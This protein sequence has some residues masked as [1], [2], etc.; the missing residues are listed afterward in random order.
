[1]RT[2]NPLL[3][4]QKELYS[5]VFMCKPLRNVTRNT[6]LACVCVLVLIKALLK[7]RINLHFNGGCVPCFTF[8][9]FSKKFIIFF[10]FE[11][12]GWL[13]EEEEE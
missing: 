7:R 2:Q 4:A 6:T 9:F 5:S 10:S 3:K 8:C 12:I 1:M 11:G 13:K